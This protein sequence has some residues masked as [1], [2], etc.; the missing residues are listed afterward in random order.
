M[1]KRWAGFYAYNK[2]TIVG[3]EHTTYFR[4]VISFGKA[5]VVEGNE[6]LE[7]FKALVEKY[8]GDQS[9]E[10]KYEKIIGCNE[11]YIIAI[12]IEHITGKEAIEY[13]K[14]KKN[15]LLI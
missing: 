3:E 4:S 7:T 13:V 12:D 5:R 10:A 8:S 2:D 14:S 15:K 1:I 6:R 9:E 11:T